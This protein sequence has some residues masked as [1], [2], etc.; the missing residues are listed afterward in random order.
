M[1]E[2]IYIVVMMLFLFGITIFV[3]EW[4]H[5]IVARK[6]GL[7]A[8]TFSIGMG[9]ALWKKEINGVV[10]K[11]GAFPVGGYVSLP[12]LDPEGMEKVQGDN[13][14]DRAALPEVSP[15]KKIAV[16]F[17]GPFCNIVFG[18]ILAWIVYL[19]S[20]LP[21][22]EE[23]PAI[24]GM[25]ST[26]STAYAEGI[27]TGDTIVQVNSKTVSNWT[28]FLVEGL[29]GV[30]K[31]Q[32]IAVTV[33]RNGQP[34]T[35]QLETVDPEDHEGQLI[36]GVDQAIPCLLGAVTKDSPADLA[37]IKA[38]DIVV[39][40]DDIPVSD[41]N[42]FT[43][44]VQ[45][46]T[47]RTVNMAIVREGVQHDLSITPEYNE[48]FD[49]VMVG[50]GLGYFRMKPMDQIKSDAFMVFRVLK[51]LVTPKE[52]GK[53]AKS[54]QGPVGIFK[55]LWNALQ[56]GFFAALG[57]VRLININLAVL[58]LLPIP[59]LDGGHICF[60]LWEGITRRKIP[61][62]VITTLVQIFAILLIGA[63]VFLSW[64]DAGG[65]RLIQK[66][67]HKAPA[68]Q[69]EQQPAPPEPQPTE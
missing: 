9:P 29:L 42:Q 39:A 64:R 54:L 3:H 8:E 63:M 51:G 59:V 57:F 52:S 22:M 31:N 14:A 32:R 61:T 62:K 21:T 4:G 35:F 60:A 33:E 19:A 20:D 41:W 65:E 30:D 50:V 1:L 66:L 48:K 26:N 5:F 69:V 12:Q 34:Q 23:Q 28:E 10:Y 56:I 27:R 44:L 18:I 47:N 2:I 17:A 6:L 15:W 36:E 16:A 43:D 24:V 7:V 53:V 13:E 49:R 67:K 11:I 37:G 40:F 45:A 55:I 68:G 38:N 25:V 46:A 58:N